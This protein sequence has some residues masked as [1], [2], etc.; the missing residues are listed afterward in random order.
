MNYHAVMICV[1]VHAFLPKDRFLF[2]HQTGDFVI[3]SQTLKTELTVCTQT[4]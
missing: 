4:P 1:V 3:F 2:A